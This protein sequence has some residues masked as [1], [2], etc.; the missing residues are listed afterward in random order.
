MA[1]AGVW[2][3]VFATL[4]GDTDFEEVFI[5]STIVRAHQHAAGAPKKRAIRPSGVLEEGSVRRF[6]RWLTAWV[7]LQN[8]DSLVGRP[9][10]VRRRYHCWV[11]CSQGVLRLT[12]H[13]TLMHSLRI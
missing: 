3:G 13:T 12:G 7:C 9:A 10:T 8:S 1:Q 2:H 4:A 11:S 6:T 5:D